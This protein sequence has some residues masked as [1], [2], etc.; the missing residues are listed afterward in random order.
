MR[1]YLKVVHQILLSILKLGSHKYVIKGNLQ[2]SESA[3]LLVELAKT[4]TAMSLLMVDGPG[5]SS[6]QSD[7]YT[8]DGLVTSPGWF[9]T[10]SLG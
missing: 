10:C 1:A 8:V 5:T 7:S 9:G 6:D 3:L 4:I 2:S